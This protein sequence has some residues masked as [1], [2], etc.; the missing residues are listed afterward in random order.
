MVKQVMYKIGKA[1][2]FIAIF[3]LAA[4]TLPYPDLST[5]EQQQVFIAFSRKIGAHDYAMVY[6]V[7][8][9]CINLIVTV[10]TYA[11]VINIS[12]YIN[13]VN[14]KHIKDYNDNVVILFIPQL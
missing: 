3:F 14:H 13:P 7:A 5:T 9:T 11:V 8:H 2:I 10:I 4:W 1:V 6:M 12:S